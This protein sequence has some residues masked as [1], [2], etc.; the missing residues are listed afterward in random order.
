MIVESGSENT[1]FIGL[2]IVHIVVKTRIETLLIFVGVLSLQNPLKQG[3]TNN[4]LTDGD[5]NAGRN[6]RPCT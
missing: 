2:Y 6:E 1:T 3:F 5:K 4:I